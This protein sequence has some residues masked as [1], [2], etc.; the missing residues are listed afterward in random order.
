ML[1]GKLIDR[2]N[3]ANCDDNRRETGSDKKYGYMPIPIE[4]KITD[5]L[6]L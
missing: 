5:N 1:V 4:N 6:L 2:I 3:G